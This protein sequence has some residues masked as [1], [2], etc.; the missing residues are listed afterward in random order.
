MEIAWASFKIL[1]ALSLARAGPMRAPRSAAQLQHGRTTD[2]HCAAE[3]REGREREGYCSELSCFLTLPLPPSVAAV[4]DVV[5]LST[6]FLLLSP[7]LHTFF[8]SPLY[9]L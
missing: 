5:S 2:D 9:L 7:S 3:W 6:A 1:V 8:F 4:V